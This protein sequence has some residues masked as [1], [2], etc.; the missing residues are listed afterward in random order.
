MGILKKLVVS[1]AAMVGLSAA[2]SAT[3]A[4]EMDDILKRGEMRVAVQTQGA[5]VAFINK[6]GEQ[7]GL[8]VELARM[9]AED[10]G[11]K[12]VIQDYDWKGLIPA[13]LAGKVDMIAADMTPTPQRS[14]QLLFS[15]PMFY[16]ET[17]AVALKDSPYT[18]W[19][20]LNKEDL[21]I[22]ST[23]ASSYSDAIKK[24][25]PEAT[26]KEYTGGTAAVSQALSSGRLDGLVSDLGNVSNFLNDFDNLKLLD[27]IVVKNP[28]SFAVRP[29]AFHLKMWLD[30]Y[31]EL[32]TSDKRLEKMVNYWW[33]TT[34]WEKDHK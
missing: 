3:Q 9:M 31:V 22:G 28:L 24:F 27:G 4:D 6:D 14:A 16:E 29:D 2:V 23:Q 15:R 7:T 11:V 12:I 13:L 20:D 21:A 33:N 19:E 5:P 26:L 8:A 32:I 17:V 10:L 25:L 34:D 1:V 30:N 18:K